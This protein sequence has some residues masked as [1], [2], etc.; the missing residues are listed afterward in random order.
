MFY[1]AVCS[2][3]RVAG[4][5]TIVQR[6]QLPIQ[7]ILESKDIVS[8]VAHA[9]KRF[10]IKKE[11]IL[12]PF[13]FASPRPDSRHCAF[14]IA[15]FRLLSF[16]CR[17]CAV[18]TYEFSN[19]TFRVR[20]IAFPELASPPIILSRLYATTDL[21]SRW[22]TIYLPLAICSSTREGHK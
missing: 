8:C 14:S 19:W 3:P 15:A 13:S 12:S 21:V 22:C 10:Q 9:A 4:H 2:P 17:T 18:S 6:L 1:A 16:D 5:R 11:D 20:F 7:G